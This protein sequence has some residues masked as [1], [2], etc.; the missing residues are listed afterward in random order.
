MSNWELVKEVVGFLLFGI[1]MYGLT[2]LVFS[3]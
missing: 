2:V 3:L 1:V